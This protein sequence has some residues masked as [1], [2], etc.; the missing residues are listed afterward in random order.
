MA[1]FSCQ[2]LVRQTKRF[3]LVKIQQLSKLYVVVLGVY[4][5]QMKNNSCLQT[6]LPIN[7]GIFFIGLA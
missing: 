4:D 6:H 5:S 2:K 1:Q 7:I 3:F